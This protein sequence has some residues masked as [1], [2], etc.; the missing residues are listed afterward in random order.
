MEKGDVYIKCG[1]DGQYMWVFYYPRGSRAQ[2]VDAVCEL[3]RQ[4]IPYP[5]IG[6]MLGISRNTV[7][8]IADTNDCPTIN[9]RGKY[10]RSHLRKKDK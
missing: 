6:L 2:H 10:D 7:K 8:A 4:G 1:K 5:K 9:E 3:I